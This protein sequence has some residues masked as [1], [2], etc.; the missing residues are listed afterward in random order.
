M[1]SRIPPARVGKLSP[2]ET[3]NSHLKMPATLR[4]PLYAAA[5]GLLLLACLA[6][7]GCGASQARAKGAG[8]TTKADGAKG[9][10]TSEAAGGTPSKSDSAA[11]KAVFAGSIDAGGGGVPAAAG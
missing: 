2:R 9:A 4:I 1:L 5:C 7:A 3:F 6:L 11:T 10:E 8:A